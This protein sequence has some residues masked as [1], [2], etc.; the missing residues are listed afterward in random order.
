MAQLCVVKPQLL[1]NTLQL[2]IPKGV[3][4]TDSIIIEKY[5]DEEDVIDDLTANV[6][7]NEDIQGVSKKYRHLFF[8]LSPSVVMLPFFAYLNMSE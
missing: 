2:K 5:I 1:G 4:L 7:L 8:F 3:N 6:V